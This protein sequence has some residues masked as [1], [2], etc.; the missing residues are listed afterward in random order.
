LGKFVFDRGLGFRDIRTRTG[1]RFYQARMATNAGGI[2]TQHARAGWL[3]KGPNATSGKP[4]PRIIPCSYARITFPELRALKGG[5][6]ADPLDRRNEAPARY[7]WF[8]GPTG[9][10][11]TLNRTVHI[12]PVQRYTHAN[13][14]IQI[15]YRRAFAATGQGRTATAGTVI[16]T[17]KPQNGVGP[18]HKKQ[19]F[20]LH[21][22]D[23]TSAV[24]SGTSL[25]VEDNVW[26]DFNLIHSEQ[27]GRPGNPN[28]LF[29]RDEFEAGQPVPVFYLL[30][31]NKITTFGTAFMFKTALP[32]TTHDML[33]NSTDT[34]V[35]KPPDG[36]LDLP[37][38]IFGEV[39]DDLGE[40]GLKRRASFDL[41]R[42]VHP[43]SPSLHV[44]SRA[45]LLDPKPGYFPSYVRQPGNRTT[46]TLDNVQLP[47]ATY[48]PDPTA[49][50]PER[51]R[52]ELAG[53]KL[54]P[55]RNRLSRQVR[56]PHL[57]NQRS[58][59]VTLNAL[60]AG[61]K[62]RTFLRF[63]N[64]RPAELGAVLWGL[65]YGNADAWTPGKSGQLRHRMGMGKPY[66]LG[67]I[68]IRLLADSLVLARNDRAPTLTSIA[69]LVKAFELEM[70][71]AV[72]NWR[73]L[74]Q[75]RTLLAA[76]D[77][78]TGAKM[79]PECLEYMILDPENRQDE[80]SDAKRDG[81]FLADYMIEETMLEA[82]EGA[83]I[84]MMVGPPK[85]GAIV[86]VPA[87]PA[88][89]RVEWIVLLDGET[90]PRRY[91]RQLFEIIG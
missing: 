62:F 44:V 48:A 72:S 31:G 90:R 40:K 89:E 33:R 47:Y 18:G 28:W 3:V 60:A 10:R 2:V 55:A 61:A 4:D 27:P 51:K 30:E 84:R 54:F 88:N 82:R 83:R 32:L 73:N 23:R 77:P 14:R 66:G 20:V 35:D 91:R 79:S 12:G 39:A 1:T 71:G 19:E 80:F 65:S 24:P 57:E 81:M 87:N 78:G 63:H 43:P 58:I 16:F 76:A 64:L 8:M 67:E 29:W 37:S 15:D 11:T 36:M 7:D 52:P 75:I 41:A 17:G 74:P 22:P 6:A 9:A 49:R 59:Q 68:S 46:G 26:R 38:L 56:P 34:H 69:D 5:N 85:E 70:G 25:N 45:I 50:E 21:T 53:V 86:G 42:I 13:G